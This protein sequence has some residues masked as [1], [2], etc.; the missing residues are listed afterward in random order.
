MCGIDDRWRSW[1][2]CPLAWRSSAQVLL[3]QPPPW[4][5]Q[6]YLRVL[7]CVRPETLARSLTRTEERDRTVTNRK[8]TAT[9]SRVPERLDCQR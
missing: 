3:G 4:R 6:R 1:S 5:R 7:E 2:S 8:A 9:K